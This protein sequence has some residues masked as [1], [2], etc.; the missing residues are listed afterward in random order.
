VIER[1]DLDLGI[2]DL[3]LESTIALVAL[4]DLWTARRRLR[5]RWMARRALQAVRLK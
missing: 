5:E 4:T 2:E 3:D 1:Y